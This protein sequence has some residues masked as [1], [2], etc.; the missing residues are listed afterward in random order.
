MI[1]GECRVEPL[2]LTGRQL[3]LDGLRLQ[4]DLRIV[5][6]GETGAAAAAAVW[7]VEDGHVATSRLGVPAIYR[8]AAVLAGLGA[9]ALAVVVWFAGTRT[10]SEERGTPTSTRVSIP[11]PSTSG[12]ASAGPALAIG[13]PGTV[14]EGSA[15]RSASTPV[16]SSRPQ[17][18]A[19]H[20]A[21]LPPEPAAPIAPRASA[22]PAVATARARG[23][24]SAEGVRQHAVP[25]RPRPT[26]PRAA[27][28][29]RDML[30]LFD[31]MK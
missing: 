28:S 29:G 14:M 19:P 6:D 9:L 20:V 26:L 7:R 5:P 16:E 30:E 25:L 13:V 23:S 17:R 10:S 8:R 1:S 31:D 22:E 3:A 27:S 21:P 12:G 4:L 18:V 11:P 15:G 2:G 24:A